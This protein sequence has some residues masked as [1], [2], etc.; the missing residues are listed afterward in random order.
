MSNL[1]DIR[2][3]GIEVI[4]GGTKHVIKFDLN[5]FA[6][7]EERFGSV[8]DAMKTLQNGSIKGIRTLVW[9]GL[10]HENEKLTEREAGAMVGVNDLEN[11]TEALS[12]SLQTTLPPQEI[13]AVTEDKKNE[14]NIKPSR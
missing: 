8:D 2:N 9:C 13:E 12:N 6:E 11:L 3:N 7:L 1:V 10:L 14:G 5:S 4:L